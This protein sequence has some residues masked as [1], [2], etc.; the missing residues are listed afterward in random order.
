MVD[1]HPSYKPYF[2]YLY[3]QDLDLNELLPAYIAEIYPNEHTVY[4]IWKNDQGYV[5][6]DGYYDFDEIEKV[7]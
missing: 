6:F 2:Q 7:C 5:D 3:Q 1:I 4:L